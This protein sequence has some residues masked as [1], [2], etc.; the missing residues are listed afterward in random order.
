[1][2]SIPS[3]NYNSEMG[4]IIGIKTKTIPRFNML[5]DKFSSEGNIEQ[6]KRYE[7]AIVK[8]KEEVIP[9]HEKAAKHWMEIAGIP[10][11]KFGQ[12]L[13]PEEVKYYE[14][15]R[16]GGTTGFPDKLFPK[17]VGVDIHS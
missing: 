6:Q 10:E 11:G 4:S 17:G 1:M 16:S 2:I 13:S 5:I 7:D 9:F 8:L 3:M 14:R 15:N 12:I